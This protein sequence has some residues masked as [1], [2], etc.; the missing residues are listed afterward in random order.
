[1]REREGKKE[2]KRKLRKK[3]TNLAAQRALS[4]LTYLLLDAAAVVLAELHV[5]S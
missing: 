2:D 5:R 3:G 1:M 4:L